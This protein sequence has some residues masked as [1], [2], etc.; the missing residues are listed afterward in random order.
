MYPSNSPMPWMD[1][2]IER[3]SVGWTL[4]LVLWN[5][6]EELSYTVPLKSIEGFKILMNFFPSGSWAGI[7]RSAIDKEFMEAYERVRDL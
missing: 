6:C 1:I 4:H 3:S 7:S 2:K 5:L